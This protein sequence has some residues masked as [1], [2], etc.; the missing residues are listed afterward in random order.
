MTHRVTA[1]AVLL[2]GLAICWLNFLLTA[3]WAA[4]PGSVHGAKE[5]FF[6][7]ALVLATALALRRPSAAREDARWVPAATAGLGAIL[8]T[9]VFF[10]CFPVWIWTR[11]PF[12]DDW[13]PRYV[14][15]VQGLELLRRGMFTGWQWGFLGGY[16]LASDVTQNL[17]LL[18]AIPMTLFGG[19][20]GF[21]LLHL[22]LFAALPALVYADLRLGD[23]PRDTALVAAG[24]VAIVSTDFTY[25]L[26][27]SGDTNSLAGTVSA[28]AA[29]V[30]AQAAR[31]GRWWGGPGLVLAMAVTNYAHRG[32][33]MYAIAFLAVDALVARD[34][35]SMRRAIVAVTA[36]WLAGLP[37]T[38]ELW[39]YPAYFDFNNVRL[40]ATPFSWIKFLRQVYY[41]SELLVR[42]GRW[43]NDYTALAVILSPIALYLVAHERGRA[44]F[45]ALGLLTVLAMGRL[46]DAQFGYAFAR[47]IHMYVVFG[48]PVMA[49][50]LVDHVRRR[51]MLA[52]WVAL[53]ALYIQI[54]WFQ[55]PHVESLRDFDAALVDHVA[56]LD[57]HLVVVENNFHADV[58]I[59]PSRRS[60]PSAFGTHFEAMLP[61]ATGR[62]LYAGFWDGWQWT[63]YRDQVFANGTFKGHRIDDVRLPEIVAELRKW[64]IRHVVVWSDPA[65]RYFAQ[66]K[67]FALRWSSGRWREF[68]FLD[69]DTRSV[70]L[71]GPGEGALER[72]DPLGGRVR[73]TGVERDENVVVR[74]NYHPSWTARAGSAEVPLFEQDGQL[75]FRAPESGTYVVALEYPRRRWLLAMALLALAGGMAVAARI[76]PSTTGTRA[77]RPA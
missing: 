16:N 65:A 68:E 34:R 25:F 71:A 54:A 75:S 27:R 18:A 17:T 60:L 14:S 47:P 74:T 31:R 45:H 76:G 32:F 55:V 61:A 49:S 62:Y 46:N 19:P 57:G 7:A 11:V 66:A 6:I 30:A 70:A 73:L 58:D 69:A 52:S 36:G 8:L 4:I 40:H 35:M 43:F 12:L 9:A 22:L 37:L 42:P 23:E 72:V 59:D 63:P 64:G 56:T 24:L 3:R 44:R 48:G 15:T 1:R 39:R 33:F 2:I 53:V 13:P 5:P 29:L 21:H 10:T 41:N 50:F 28:T 26:I 77:A 67:P 20:V 38:W 51:A